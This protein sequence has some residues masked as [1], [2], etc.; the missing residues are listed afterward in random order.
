MVELLTWSV[1][2][3]RIKRDAKDADIEE[4]IRFGQALDMVQVCKG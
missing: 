3:S 2:D 1:T 4:G